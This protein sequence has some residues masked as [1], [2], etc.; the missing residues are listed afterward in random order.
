MKKAILVSIL[1]ALVGTFAATFVP[2]PQDV[3]S[4]PAPVAPAPEPKPI[5]A[6]KPKPRKP[7]GP[8]CSAAVSRGSAVRDGSVHNGEQVQ[9]DLPADQLVR[10]TGGS[11]GAGLCVFTSIM[12]AA[13]LQNVPQLKNFQAWM[14]KH[15][16]GGWPQ[17]VDSMIAAY[18]KEQGL[19]IPDYI[20][21]ENGDWNLVKLALRTG[22]MPAITY[23]S[24]HMVNIVK[25]EN[26]VGAFRDNN[27][28][29][30]K[31][32]AWMSEDA[33]KQTSGGSH[34]WSVILLAPR[35]PMP[36]KN[37]AATCSAPYVSGSYE[38]RRFP[39]CLQW[40]LWRDG[41]QVGNYDADE[42]RY[43]V[44][45]DGM[46]GPFYRR[47]PVTL[48]DE[49]YV[50]IADRVPGGAWFSLE[51]APRYSRNGIVVSRE[52]AFAALKLEDDSKKP[53]LTVIGSQ[54]QQ[55][56]VR[57]AFVASDLASRFIFQ[58]YSPDEW[59]VSTER[60]GFA[61][62]GQPTIYLQKPDGGVLLHL[63]GFD[64][65]TLAQLRLKD[66]NYNPAND[67]GV[68]PEPS[69]ASLTPDFMPLVFAGVAVV[70]TLLLLT[71]ESK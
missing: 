23:G 43:G 20:Q 35:P 49:A 52:E 3:P 60:F 18:C 8:N 40:S 62:D 38:W 51:T 55:D 45:H 7:W 46:W 11:D 50:H 26:G 69:I 2:Q 39:D 59:A 57:A 22:R 17:K 48:P 29:G 30:E 37:A 53:S 32:I 4:E 25:L 19:P 28:V 21:V 47:P 24:A 10:N 58:S 33:A 12:F 65:N 44:H 9:A 16:G 34:F 13:R 41:E 67:P 64:G 1:L 14:K 5:P 27:F 31:E 54:E 71:K 61:H 68:K 56:A 6:P 66:P 42:D 63:R 15:P 36:P 70:I